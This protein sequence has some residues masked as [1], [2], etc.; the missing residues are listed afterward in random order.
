[1]YHKKIYLFKVSS[2]LTPI[3]ETWLTTKTKIQVPLVASN[4]DT[5]ISDELGDVL[6][7][8]GSFPIFHRF[9]TF[10]KVNF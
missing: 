7:K 5:V 10:E 2:R 4:M 3:L 1:M 8:N 9:T 6:L